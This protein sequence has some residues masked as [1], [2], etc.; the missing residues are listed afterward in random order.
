[1]ERGQLLHGA[2]RVPS[3]R[4]PSCGTQPPQLHLHWQPRKLLSLPI[5]SHTDRG[6]GLVG[7]W[8]GVS[9]HHL[10]TLHEGQAHSLVTREAHYTGWGVRGPLQKRHYCFHTH[11]A[12]LQ[13]AK[14]LWSKP[15][16]WSRPGGPGHPRPIPNH[17]LSSTFKD[18]SQELPGLYLLT[19]IS[20]KA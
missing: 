7:S 15:P 8:V 4:V 10:H 13:E 17:K 1:M 19:H 9:T 2:P 12:A 11:P 6:W 3:P 18:Y 16:L 14:P 20:S 5:R